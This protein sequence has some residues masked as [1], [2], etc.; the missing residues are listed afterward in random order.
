MPEFQVV[1]DYHP[2]GDQPEAIRQ[3]V[4]GV[5]AGLVHQTL[6]GATG[7]GKTY[8]IAKLIERV[9]IYLIL[10][11]NYGLPTIFNRELVGALP[12]SGDVSMLLE[13]PENDPVL[14]IEMIA[15]TYKNR[16]Y[17]YRHS[18]CIAGERKIFREY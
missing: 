5:E 15:M 18:Y 14:Y 1:S 9:P 12:A 16:P 13:I 17:E 10:E 3:L 11:R 7:T 8:T 2:T 6:L 4:E